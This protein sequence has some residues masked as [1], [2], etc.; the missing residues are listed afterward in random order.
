MS[1]PVGNCPGCGGDEPF[2]Q[3]HAGVCP[4]TGTECLEW[5]CVSCGAAVFMGIAPA[6]SSPRVAA[7]RDG[8]SGTDGPGS[9]VPASAARQS[10]RAA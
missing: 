5:A 9:P 1:Q 7:A 2:E 8:V 4:D 6:A 10:V 3:I